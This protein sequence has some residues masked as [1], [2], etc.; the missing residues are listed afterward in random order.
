MADNWKILTKVPDLPDQVIKSLDKAVSTLS[1]A[2]TALTKVLKLLQFFISSFSSFSAI[3]QTFV[4]FA[5][6]QLAQFTG[7][8]LS[9]GVYYNILIPPAFLKAI[10]DSRNS[11]GGYNGFLQRLKVS[12]NNP[13]DK[14]AP[15]FSQNAQMGGF[16]I[17]CDTETLI[18]FYKGL[19]FLADMFD[20]FKLFP[21]DLEPLP[22]RNVRTVS[23]YFDYGDGTRKLGVKV[24]WDAPRVTGF[25]QYRLSRSQKRGG[26]YTI[27]HPIPDKLFGPKGKAKEGLLVAAQ[28]RLASGSGEWPPVEKWEYNDPA[29][30]KGNPVVVRAN[31]VNG[32]GSYIDFDVPPDSVEISKE[33]FYV[34][35][36]GFV[37]LYGPR[38]PEVMA[39][40]NLK[41]C[42][43]ADQQ[44]VVLQKGGNLEFISSGSG[45][46]GQWSS[47]QTRAV[48]PFLDTVVDMLNKFV[49]GLAGALKTN[50]KSFTD[51]LNGML[52]KINGY[53]D[54]LN[55][56]LGIIIAIEN[57]FTGAPRIA[58]L[59]IPPAV[60]GTTNFM[61]RVTNAVQPPGGFTGVNGYTVGI[62]F[63]YGEVNLE[64]DGSMTQAD[65]EVLKK[66]LQVKSDALGKAF[67]L[68]L[69]ALS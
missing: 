13:A 22:P 19:R 52:K 30:N 3:L 27:T 65:F 54:I 40:V 42:I 29:F 64:Y 56:L 43:N 39:V 57:F 21:I 46:L 25:T 69:K 12:L 15:R 32:G 41:G 55:T 61:S 66:A 47:I 5:Q 31:P 20:F 2:L 37:G 17:L 23:G 7:D 9:G 10:S 6:K 62:V 48:I 14:N 49:G 60:G 18:D 36:S 16:I 35:E 4:T 50:S 11:T 38:T 28:Y 63:A 34:V 67:S 24:S 53:K 45:S 1:T 8:L 59:N 44:A 51:F 68:L 58:F 26:V 33:Y